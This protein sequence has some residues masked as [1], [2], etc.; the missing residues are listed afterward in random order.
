MSDKQGGFFVV[1]VVF[2]FGGGAG[3]RFSEMNIYLV[4]NA[5]FTVN[6]VP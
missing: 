4:V 3:G 1:V 5:S 6:V 2:F